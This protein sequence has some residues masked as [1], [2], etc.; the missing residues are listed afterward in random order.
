MDKKYRYLLK[1]TSILTLSNFATKVLTFFLVPLYTSVLST[2]EYGTY[3]LIVSTVSM[4]YPVLTCNIVDGV[5][6]F[7]MDRRGQEKQIFTIG[8][9]FSLVSCFA[10]TGIT[11]IVSH[12]NLFSGIRGL[13]A[14]VILYYIGSVFTQLLMQFAKGLERV[15]DMAVAGVLGVVVTVVANL[16]FLLGLHWGLK[17]FFLA[18][19]LAHVTE[20]LYY[21]LRLQIWRFWTNKKTDKQLLR[22]MLLYC[23][24]LITTALSWTINS[25]A[26]KYIVT[27]ALGTAANGLLA[28]AYKIPNILSVFQSIFTQAWQI[29]GVKEYGADESD[30]FYGKIFSVSN[31][32]MSLACSCLIL[33][34]KPMATLLYAK[35]FYVAWKYVPFLLITTVLNSAS[36]VLGPI[37]SAKKDSKGM[38][39]S[40]MWGICANIILNIALVYAM[41][42]QGVTIA[43][44]ISSAVIFAV[45]RKHV[46]NAI[47]D[48]YP[49]RTILTWIL[50]CGQ[51]MVAV[52]L[53]Q[54]IWLEVFMIAIVIAIN[55]PIIN[56]VGKFVVRIVL[57][58]L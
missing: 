3:D 15:G 38:A 19:I 55:F 12:L 4:L 5:M 35:D 32:L 39:V 33:L 14:Y 52:W 7:L 22:N 56:K 45:R 37:L 13:E 58:N 40:A 53:Q 44:A 27:F 16:T 43:T 46:G 24:P 50:L 2:Y 54:L 34:T 8:M 17:G 10:A 47:K 41:G 1:N 20:V 21:A 49:L 28:V 51:A 42:I 29:S 26:D 31:M 11:L 6:R 36:G 30:V 23:V 18:Y 48:Q 57:R 9:K 25:S